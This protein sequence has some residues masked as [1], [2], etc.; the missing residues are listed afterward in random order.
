MFQRPI[1]W[2][3]IY[4]HQWFVVVESKSHLHPMTERNRPRFRGERKS[5]VDVRKSSGD[6]NQDSF[7]RY[8]YCKL[9]TGRKPACD[10][11]P[12]AHCA[13]SR[14]RLDREE[15]QEQAGGDRN[16]PRFRGERK[17]RVDVRKSS[18]DINQ[19]SFVRYT[20]C[21]LSTGRKPACDGTPP[22][23]CAGSRARLDREERQEQAGG[24]RVRVVR[25]DI[26]H[27]DCN[28]IWNTAYLV[29]YA[30][31]HYQSNRRISHGKH[32]I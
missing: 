2:F 6:I 23:H 13:G 31:F 15:R 24:D 1:H 19:D 17:S 9:S 22:A 26:G 10:G 7:V 27:N 28:R 14:A 8:T 25:V 30:Y 16:R 12:P 5:R 21:K 3:H 20:Y 4:Y 32:F 11:T 18:G 29:S